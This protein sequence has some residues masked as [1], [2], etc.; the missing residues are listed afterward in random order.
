VRVGYKH[1]WLMVGLN[2]IYQDYGTYRLPES[3]PISLS[4]LTFLPSAGL[5]FRI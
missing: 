5:E 2:V 4:G 1:A 3:D